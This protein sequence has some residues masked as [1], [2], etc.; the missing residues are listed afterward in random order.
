MTLRR[1]SI[2]LALGL[3]AAGLLGPV[4]PLSAQESTDAGTALP[5]SRDGPPRVSLARTASN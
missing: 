2:A 4:A 5:E 1:V 3:A